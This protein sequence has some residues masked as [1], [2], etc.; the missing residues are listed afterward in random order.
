MVLA[1]VV[2]IVFVAR[3]GDK[4]KT[5]ATTTTAGVTTTTALVS[6]AGKPCVKVSDALPKGAPE[7]PVKTGPPPT[8]LLKED[9]KVGSG[10]AVKPN[11]N[12]MVN[13]IGVLCSTGKVLDSS[14]K[15]GKPVPIPAQL[16]G[17]VIKGWTEGIPGMRVGGSRLLGIPPA[18]AYGSQ[19]N[20]PIAPDETLWFV[21]SVASTK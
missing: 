6:V 2:A 7:V 17:S 15:T 3:S 20:P 21:V 19:S 14:Y 11:A 9:L 5:S 1:T 4:N 13:Y 12:V 16:G 18:L 8:S 10:A